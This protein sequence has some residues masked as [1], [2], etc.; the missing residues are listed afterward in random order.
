MPPVVKEYYEEEESE[1]HKSGLKEHQIDVNVHSK[2]TTYLR[3][4]FLE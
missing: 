1:N 2:E 3:I 4:M